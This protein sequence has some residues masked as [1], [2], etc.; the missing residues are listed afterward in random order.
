MLALVALLD[1]EH[2]RV[3]RQR[4]THYQANA[5]SADNPQALLS[6]L[7]RENGPFDLATTIPSAAQKR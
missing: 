2:R 6:A 1:I 5:E 3:V 7:S 4:Q